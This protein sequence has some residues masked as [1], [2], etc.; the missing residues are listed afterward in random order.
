MIV[1]VLLAAFVVG[2]LAGGGAVKWWEDQ[3]ENRRLVA[4]Q[5]A[6]E[7]ID[8]L[9]EKVKQETENKL[10]DMKAAFDAGEANAKI[11]TKTVYIKGQDIVRDSPALSSPQCVL[12]DAGLQLH[13]SETA[14]VRLAAAEALGITLPV[15]GGSG[16]GTVRGS[17]HIQAGT[18]KPVPG[19]RQ[20]LQ[21]VQS[22]D[23]GAGS[24]VQRPT[25]P[26][27]K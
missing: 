13:N 22:T 17:V 27:R 2:G 20:E 11:V 26:L 1:Y 7:K 3:A 8:Q 16:D 4:Q 21:P 9:T 19:V 12:P 6:Q 14:R 23:G 25:N 24:S 10:I 18:P 5:K 15:A